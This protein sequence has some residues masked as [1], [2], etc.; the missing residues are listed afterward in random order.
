MRASTP[1]GS[2]GLSKTPPS[3]NPLKV[4]KSAEEALSYLQ[5]DAKAK[6]GLI[7]TDLALPGMNGMAFLATLREQ[8][9]LRRIPV[10]I[11]TS[12]RS[13][14]HKND[15]FDM[16]AAGFIVKPA[17]YEGLV[18]AVRTIDAYWTLSELP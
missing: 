18:E 8:A 10:V 3:P 14:W 1:C 16:G 6:P 5:N 9:D 4:V 12:S 13:D 11:L 15:C 2:C 17:T 7:I